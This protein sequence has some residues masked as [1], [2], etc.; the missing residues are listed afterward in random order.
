MT[1]E[2]KSVEGFRKR[3]ISGLSAGVELSRKC[4]EASHP[5]ERPDINF[6]AYLNGMERS[7]EFIKEIEYP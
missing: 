4:Y 5:N 6:L 7:I 3:L 1:K 2:K